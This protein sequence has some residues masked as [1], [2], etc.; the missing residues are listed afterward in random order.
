M[1]L[2]NAYQTYK[3]AMESLPL[4][5]KYSKE[6][7]LVD[8]FKM[9][10]FE[11][12]A[13]YYSPHNEYINPSAKILVVG[14]TPGWNQMRIAYEEARAC[15]NLELPQEEILCRA[16]HAARLAGT[17]RSNLI[18]ML[19]ELGLHEYLLIPS[20][21]V[22]FDEECKLLHTTSVLRYPVFVDGR[23]YSGSHPDLLS[24]PFFHDYACSA[25]LEE[26]KLLD[27]PLVVPLGKSV[28]NI[29]MY[30][31]KRGDVNYEDCLWGFPHPSGANG[32]RKKQFRQ[33][34]EAMRT[35]LKKRWRGAERNRE[36][37]NL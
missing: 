17:I 14:I 19:D 2:K 6:Q 13:M 11:K 1:L 21:N 23:N 32:H 12:M 7:L 26:I 5:K 34:Y 18:E 25:L 16:K 28:E 35:A 3:L 4:N 30:L 33:N 15:L 10:S 27:A 24:V 20:A 8:E 31:A 36:T 22:L 9:L 29:L 37:S